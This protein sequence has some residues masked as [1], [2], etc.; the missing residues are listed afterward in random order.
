M[1]L[2]FFTNTIVSAVSMLPMD[3]S[4]V[5]DVL[6]FMCTDLARS[7]GHILFLTANEDV[8]CRD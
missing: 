1:L 7:T 6:I 4:S 2:G 5:Y 8:E 3:N